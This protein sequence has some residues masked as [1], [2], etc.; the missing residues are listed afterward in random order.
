MGGMD[1]SMTLTNR[2]QLRAF[3]EGYRIFEVVYRAG[4]D[5]MIYL[6]KLAPRAGG[7][8][9]EMKIVVNDRGNFLGFKQKVTSGS[10]PIEVEV[11]NEGSIKKAHLVV[12]GQEYGSLY[13]RSGLRAA[14][15][16]YDKAH[17][18]LFLNHVGHEL[19]VIKPRLIY[20]IGNTTEDIRANVLKAFDRIH[21][22]SSIM[23]PQESFKVELLESTD[24]NV[25]IS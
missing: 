17:K 8:D 12:F 15:Y 4:E 13:G 23:V 5:G 9:Y 22:E 16:H 14:W 6:R 25:P 19:G 24:A 3:I 21:L 18:G 10:K 1:L 7:D 2:Y 20:T 11:V